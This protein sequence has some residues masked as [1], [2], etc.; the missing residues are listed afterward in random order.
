MKYKKLLM[1]KITIPRNIQWILFIGN[2]LNFVWKIG[3]FDIIVHG[4]NCVHSM[5]AGLA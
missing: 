3:K 4:C 1:I 5:G 2:L